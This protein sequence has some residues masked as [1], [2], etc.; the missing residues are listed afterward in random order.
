MR[1]VVRAWHVSQFKTSN[2]D[3]NLKGQ[4]K[5]IEHLPVYVLNKVFLTIQ[6]SGHCNVVRWSL[7]G[8]LSESG[9]KWSIP[10]QNCFF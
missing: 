1:G 6:L 2:A 8:A 4:L 7:L 3:Q 5:I 9:G 10:L